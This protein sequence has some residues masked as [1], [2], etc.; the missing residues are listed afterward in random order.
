MASHLNNIT[1]TEE[2][3]EVK[4]DQVMVTRLANTS[5]KIYAQRFRCYHQVTH[6]W[7]PC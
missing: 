2:T 1:V 4:N 3:I 5:F 7:K 6:K